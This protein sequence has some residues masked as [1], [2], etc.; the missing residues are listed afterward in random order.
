MGLTIEPHSHNLKREKLTSTLAHRQGRSMLDPNKNTQEEIMPT[1]GKALGKAVGCALSLSTLTA[2]PQSAQ[3][4]SVADF[5]RDNTINLIISFPVGGGY[6]IYGR[7]VSRYMGKHIPG[8]PKMVPQN[9]IGAGGMKGANFMYG[10]APKDGTTLGIIPDTAPSEELLGTNGVAYVS[11]NFNWVGRISASTN[12]Q[13]LWATSGVKTIADAQAKESVQGGS[14]PMAPAVIYP[15][16][17]NALGGTKFKMVTGYGG[18][19]ESCLAMEK[20]EIDGCLLAWSTVKAAKRDWLEQKKASIVVQWGSTRHPELPDIPTMVE[21][22]K[23]AEDKA[24]LEL[25]ASATEIGK[26]IVAPPGVAKDRITALRRGFDAMLKDP[27]YLEEVRRLSL[28]FEPLSGEKLQAYVEE[29][30]KTPANVLAKAKQV[31]DN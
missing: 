24:I 22:G 8:N 18:A 20:G 23:T 31:R 9:M 16:L 11:K 28:D 14:G 21:M 3:A 27:D 1:I 10:V 5:Y 17:L 26:S 29:L 13:V 7:L 30:S 15:K 12:V 2:L 25:Y 6:D 4:Q 19:A